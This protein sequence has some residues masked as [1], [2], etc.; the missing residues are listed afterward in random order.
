MAMGFFHTFVDPYLYTK[1][2]GTKITVIVLYVDD[3]LIEGSCWK[4]FVKVREDVSSKDKSDVGSQHSKFLEMNIENVCRDVFIHYS[5][6]V[7]KLFSHFQITAPEHT[8]LKSYQK[9]IGRLMYLNGTRR[10]DIVYVTNYLAQF[11]RKTQ[12]DIWVG[13]K[14]VF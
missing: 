6:A 3:F 2:D 10:P 7:Q 13:S 5:I 1:A 8:N 11:L 9:L 14:H 12:K 4:V